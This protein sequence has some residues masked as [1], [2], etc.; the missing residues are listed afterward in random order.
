MGG[1]QVLTQCRR[2]CPGWCQPWTL[3]GRRRRQQLADELDQRVC[4]SV[5]LSVSWTCS[6]TAPS[7]PKPKVFEAQAKASD[8]RRQ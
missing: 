8:F 4:L 3:I 2:H 7:T 1:A 5:S 6:T